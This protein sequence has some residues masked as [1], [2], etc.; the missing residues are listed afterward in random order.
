MSRSFDQRSLIDLLKTNPLKI[1]VYFNE[2]NE[3]ADGDYIFLDHILDV[4]I[5]HDN[6]ACYKNDVLISVY[7]KNMDNL[8]KTVQFLRE[9]FIYSPTYTEDSGYSV[10]SG[11]VQLFVSDW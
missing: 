4:S 11:D 8:H 3:L 1:K 9:H 10:A 2:L 5:S 7:C 6:E